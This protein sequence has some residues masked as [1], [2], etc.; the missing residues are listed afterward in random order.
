MIKSFEEQ[1]RNGV[2]LGIIGAKLM[3]YH[4][5]SLIQAVGATYNKWFA[6]TR[7]VGCNEPDWGQYDE[8][9]NNVVLDYI[10]GAS[11]VVSR[12]FLVKVG[13]MN[14]DFFLYFEELDWVLR[15]KR[16]GFTFTYC[17]KSIVYHKEGKA[18]GGSS[19]QE[20]KSYLADFYNINNRIAITKRYFPFYR[21]SV[22]LSLIGSMLNRIRRGQFS[23]IKMILAIVFDSFFS[24]PR[25]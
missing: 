22:Y 25:N 14:P 7:H 8:N 15:G 2:K 17:P 20:N 4:N 16:Y 19:K 13:L 9:P 11:M 12:E 21:F 5:P 3:Y 23:R 10:V 24:P 1:V 6:T 18:T